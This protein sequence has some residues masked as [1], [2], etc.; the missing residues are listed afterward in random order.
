MNILPVLFSNCLV[1]EQGNTLLRVNLILT[2]IV[3]EGL[4][5][6]TIRYQGPPFS[7]GCI[8]KDLQD[9]DSFNLL[10]QE[11][12]YPS[13]YDQRILKLPSWSLWQS[14]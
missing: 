10:D 12:P 4:V 2:G 13:E 1:S 14:G 9:I 8:S 3:Y 5:D 6:D 11:Y 7:N